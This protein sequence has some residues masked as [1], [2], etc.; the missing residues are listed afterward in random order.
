MNRGPDLRFVV[1]AIFKPLVPKLNSIQVIKLMD[2]GRVTRPRGEYSSLVCAVAI[3]DV[4]ERK[5]DVGE[6]WWNHLVCT[7]NKNL[8]RNQHTRDY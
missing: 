1:E 7:N 2:R 6:S 4:V 3:Y 5:Y 8:D